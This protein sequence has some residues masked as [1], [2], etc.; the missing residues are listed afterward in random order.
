[1]K[2]GRNSML[3]CSRLKHICAPK[4]M[5]WWSSSNSTRG[6][7]DRVEL[8]GYFLTELKKLDRSCDFGDLH[9]SLSR[10]LIVL[11]ISDRSLQERLLRKTELTLQK[12]Q[13]ETITRADK[14][15]L[16]AEVKS[17]TSQG[18]PCTSSR[19]S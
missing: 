4:S 8:F 5:W 7:R 17:S 6:F 15:L 14:L 1:M 2:I 3:L 9:D 12:Y 11:G 13:V 16:M 18:I 19:A 10:D